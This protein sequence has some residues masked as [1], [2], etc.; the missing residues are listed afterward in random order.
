MSGEFDVC[1]VGSFMK[2]LVARV[3]RLPRRGETLHGEDFAE[4]LGGK[5]VN[6]A[7]AAARSGARTAIVGRL[8]ADRYGEEFLA[9]LA[10]EGID[11]ERVSVREGAGTGVGLPVVEPDGSNAIVIVPRANATLTAADIGAAADRIAGA[12]IVTV[13]LELPME[14]AVEALRIASAAGTTTILNPAPMHPSLPPDLLAYAD[15][16]VPNAVEAEQLTGRHCDGDE[17]LAVAVETA[18]R[19]CRR[20]C[21]LTLGE[22]GSI[23]VEGGDPVWLPAH[24][25]ATVDTVGAGDAFCGALAARLAAGDSLVEAARYANA[26]GGLST[27]IAGAV[28]GIP[29]T[30][31]ISALLAKATLVDD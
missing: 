28:D 21:V 15:I 14:T 31:A 3:P 24:Q 30:E 19:F 20:G 29:S 16:V 1:V 17:A 25:V 2:D 27:T 23:V 9:L 26:A 10:A 8:G 4:F 11:A 18:E 13:Q 12:S 22:R 6:Q 7:V 5:G